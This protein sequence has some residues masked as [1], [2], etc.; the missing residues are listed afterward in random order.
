MRMFRT[1]VYMQFLDDL[2]AQTVMGNHPTDS[3][4]NHSYRVVLQHI[5]CFGVFIAAQ[6]PGMTEVNL[7]DQFLAGQFHLGLPGICPPF[8]GRF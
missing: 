7:L 2:I 6:I 3:Q 1:S 5:P 4:F 8:Q